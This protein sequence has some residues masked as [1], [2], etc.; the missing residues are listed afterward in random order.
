M[1]GLGKKGTHR[2]G[3]TESLGW[4]IRL[5]QSQ[6]KRSCDPV[7]LKHAAGFFMVGVVEPPLKP[8]TTAE[9]SVLHR[10]ALPTNAV[11]ASAEA[12]GD[13]RERN[14]ERRRAKIDGHFRVGRDFRQRMGER[15]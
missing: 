2:D 14:V 15:R 13:I 6:R 5:L 1:N 7:A 9:L 11:I 3:G 10:N 12:A 8:A 4:L